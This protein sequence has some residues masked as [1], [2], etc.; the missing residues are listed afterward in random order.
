MCLALHP[1]QVSLAP[2]LVGMAMQPLPL[3]LAPLPAWGLAMQQ[4]P[5]PQTER[6]TTRT[7]YRMCL[8]MH[9]LRG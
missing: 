1:L 8:A 9:P 2:L 7:R 4:H 3:R 5:R 6:A